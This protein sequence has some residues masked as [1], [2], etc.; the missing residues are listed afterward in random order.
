MQEIFCILWF[1]LLVVGFGLLICGL[2]GL[3]RLSKILEEVV[4]DE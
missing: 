1:A 2:I 3:H 4:P